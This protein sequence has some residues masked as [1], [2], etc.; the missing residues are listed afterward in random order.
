[1]ASYNMNQVK[2]GLKIMVDGDPC[3]IGVPQRGTV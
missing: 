3:V 1:M 2:V